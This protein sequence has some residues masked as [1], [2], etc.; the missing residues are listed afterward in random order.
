VFTLVVD[1][2][3]HLVKEGIASRL[4]T[5]L[6]GLAVRVNLFYN[7]VIIKAWPIYPIWSY[8]RRIWA[9]LGEFTKPNM[10]DN[11]SRL[12][13]FQLSFYLYRAIKNHNRAY[14]AF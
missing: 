10:L 1:N 7:I 6:T 12:P 14:M 3:S 4:V 2:H 11:L 8:Y 5:N 13:Q 9:I